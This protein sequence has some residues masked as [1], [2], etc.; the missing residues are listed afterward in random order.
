M[1][2]RAAR[3][4]TTTL[5]HGAGRGSQEV[6]H[7][8]GSPS[9][10]A[11]CAEWLAAGRAGHNVAAGVQWHVEH[12]WSAGDADGWQFAGVWVA[13]WVS[14]RPDQVGVKVVPGLEVMG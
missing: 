2:G 9:V 13:G 7:G 5:H 12:C 6:E 4:G 3:G 8:C 14:V 1:G 11:R 10:A